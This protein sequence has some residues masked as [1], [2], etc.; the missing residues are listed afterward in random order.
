[1]SSDNEDNVIELKP[2]PPELF[3]KV[4]GSEGLTDDQNKEIE[5]ALSARGCLSPYVDVV[6]DGPPGPE[7]GR[8]VE[9]ED[10]EGASVRAGVWIDRGDGY[11]A[12][13]LKLADQKIDKPPRSAEPIQ[14]VPTQADLN[15]EE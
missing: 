13:R 2:T 14:E 3:W 8:F 4:H 9:V 10:M 12:L 15:T 1:M 11:W 7:S 6:F 5:A